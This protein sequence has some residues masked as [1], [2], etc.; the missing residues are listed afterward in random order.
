MNGSHKC[1][2]GNGEMKDETGRRQQSEKKLENLEKRSDN[3]G[4]KPMA[5]W[6]AP[7]LEVKKIENC[8][9]T[10]ICSWQSCWTVDP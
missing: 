8:N 1:T 4:R 5:L 10:S 6:R 9:N 3:T 7:R 2:K